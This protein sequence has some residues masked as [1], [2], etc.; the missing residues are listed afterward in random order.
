M[1]FNRHVKEYLPGYALG[2]LEANERRIVE[3]HLRGCLDCQRELHSYQET[4]GLLAF[5]V[6]QV[7]PPSEVKEKLMEHVRRTSQREFVP[8][9]GS[10]WK[11]S[12]RQVFTNLAP[13]WAIASLLLVLILGAS[14]FILWRQVQKVRADLTT[15]LRVVALAGTDESPSASGVI[16]ISR[17]G[18]HGTIVVDRLK[19]LSEEQQYQLWL[20]EDGERVS[21]AVFS[22]G[23]DGY[24]SAYIKS[25]KPLIDYDGFGVTIEPAGG[26]PAPTG[27]K[28]LGGDL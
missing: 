16:V 4:A 28:V 1:G 12:F 21:G 11:D 14:N 15:P 26:S 13:V 2:C 7:T 18:M 8:V 6:P 20:I 27:V 3:Q 23:K 17:D 9:I 5:S 10:S 22:V 19:T 25:P 24:A